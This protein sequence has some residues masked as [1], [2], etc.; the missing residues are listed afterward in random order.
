MGSA[1]TVQLDR[2]DF[3]ND[4]GSKESRERDMAQL[5]GT[6]NTRDITKTS[7]MV[8]LKEYTGPGDKN[9]PNDPAVFKIPLQ[10]ALFGQRLLW[11]GRLNQF[12][13]SIGSITLLD[14]Y[15]AMVA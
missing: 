12:H 11:Q 7:V 5:I 3:W 14:D 10:K 1:D 8:E 2:Y 4:P 15:V 9:K 6:A 13:Q